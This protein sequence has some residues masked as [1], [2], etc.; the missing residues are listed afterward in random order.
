M[1]FYTLSILRQSFNIT[2]TASDN[3]NILQTYRQFYSFVAAGLKNE[4]LTLQ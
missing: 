1:H 4:A 2:L 3:M